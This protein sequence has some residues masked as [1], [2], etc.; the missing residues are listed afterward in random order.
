MNSAV[1]S[2]ADQQ[3]IE[4]VNRRNRWLTHWRIAVL[5]LIALWF[6]IYIVGLSTPALLDDAD[7]VHAEAARDA[8]KHCREM[9]QTP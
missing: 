4:T 9:L 5:V 8:V 3:T 7:T 2:R 6:V 1:T